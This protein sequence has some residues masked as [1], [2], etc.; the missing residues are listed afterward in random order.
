[1]KLY[2]ILILTFLSPTII[3]QFDWIGNYYLLKECI[4]STDP[5]EFDSY[6]YRKSKKIKSIKI[7]TLVNNNFL[8]IS[9]RK[10]SIT[11]KNLI[12]NNETFHYPRIEYYNF[13]ESGITTEYKNYPIS[14]YITKE[15]SIDSNYKIYK[16]RRK[17]KCEISEYIENCKSI[18][19]NYF[20]KGLLKKAVTKNHES[21]FKHDLNNNIVEINN[22]GRKTCFSKYSRDSIIHTFIYFDSTE[23]R[24]RKYLMKIELDSL[25]RIKQSMTYEDENS[26][27]VSYAKVNRDLYGNITEIIRGYSPSYE[28]YEVFIELKNEYKNGILVSITEYFPSGNSKSWIKYKYENGLLVE[29]EYEGGG[30]KKYSYTF[31]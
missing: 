28:D 31:Y 2:I 19:L 1:M 29:K 13:S 26:D 18:S 7:E 3:A 21:T 25:G 5:T 12:R 30:L 8:D 10:D 4:I 23:L 20:E 16:L 22:N 24:N 17:G 14:K 27:I 15:D 9:E 6:L 11:F